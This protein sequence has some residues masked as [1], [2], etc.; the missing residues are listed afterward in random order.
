M[1]ILN[2]SQQFLIQ[3]HSSSLK[4]QKNFCQRDNVI[5]IITGSLNFLYEVNYENGD[6]LIIFSAFNR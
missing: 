2:P 5:K 3:G 1:Q 6:D 4:I